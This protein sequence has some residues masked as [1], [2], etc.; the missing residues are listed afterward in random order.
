VNTD[1]MWDEA[2]E[3]ELELATLE[4]EIE[5]FRSDYLRAVGILIAEYHDVEARIADL[6]RTG[7][8]ALD[9]RDERGR[10]VVHPSVRARLERMAGVATS[11]VR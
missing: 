11:R 6:V 7:L 5:A 1:A 8:A 10:P 4:A 2:A 3:L 9:R